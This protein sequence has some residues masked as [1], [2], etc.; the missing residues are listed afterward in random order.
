MIID[1]GILFYIGV[2]GRYIGLRLVV[3]VIGYKILDG[4]VRK[5]GFHFAV[6]LSRQRLVVRQDH[7]RTVKPCNHV[8][9]G[10]GLT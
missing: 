10:E 1:R 4:I 7:G 8:G 5:K 2:G 6:Q 9:H 3:I